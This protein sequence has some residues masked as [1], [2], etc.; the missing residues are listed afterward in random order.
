MPLGP[1]YYTGKDFPSSSIRFGFHVEDERVSA[2]SYSLTR[3]QF[4]D[5]D[6]F[7]SPQAVTGG[8]AIPDAVWVSLAT[9]LEVLVPSETAFSLY[10]F[11]QPHGTLIHYAG[12][13]RLQQDEYVLCISSPLDGRGSYVESVTVLA[14]IPGTS[15]PKDL[16]APFGGF[17]G[18][19]QSQQALGL[20]PEEVVTSFQD[21]PKSCFTTPLSAWDAQP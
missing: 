10:L 8:L 4:E 7:L 11:F 18:M 21:E 5:R 2:I 12:V 19:L 6:E 13:A 17:G 15:R 3:P 14:G 9:G 16:T 1:V 20:S